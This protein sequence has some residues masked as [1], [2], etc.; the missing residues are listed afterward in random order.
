M[1]PEDTIIWTRF[2][3]GGNTGLDECYYDVRVGEAVAVE[4]GQPDWMK[5]MVGYNSRKRIDIVGRAGSNWWVIE[6]KPGAGVVAL[7]QAIVYA[8]L[9]WKEFRSLGSVIPA[10]I[11]DN[12]D[13]DVGPIMDLMGVRVLEVGLAGSES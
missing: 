13:G 5:R 3:G 12:C 1:M 2:L 4:S 6:A 11:T 8:V 10:V 7:G 9:F